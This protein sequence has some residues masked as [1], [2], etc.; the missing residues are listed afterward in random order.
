MSVCTSV[1]DPDRT[2]GGARHLDQFTK[3]GKAGTCMKEFSNPEYFVDQCVKE[4]QEE[5]EKARQEKKQRRKERRERV[6]LL[7]LDRLFLPFHKLTVCHA[8]VSDSNPMRCGAQRQ[9]MEQ[10]GRVKAEKA[11]LKKKQFK[12]PE[13]SEII[14]SG[15]GQPAS[16]VLLLFLDAC[17]LHPFADAWLCVLSILSRASAPTAA[18]TGREKPPKQKLY[19]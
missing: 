13:F 18:A 10:G 3:D 19:A 7:P 9:K 15:R 6:R 16:S 2:C 4:R 5:M 14:P 8:S 17:Q 12:Q 1:S 11:E